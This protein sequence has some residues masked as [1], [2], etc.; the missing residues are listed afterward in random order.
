MKEQT[1]NHNREFEEAEIVTGPQSKTTKRF[2]AGQNFATNQARN[3]M[4][5]FKKQAFLF[6]FAWVSA[7]VFGIIGFFTLIGWILFS[8]LPDALAGFLFAI[9]ILPVMVIV[10]V[11]YKSLRFVSKKS[12]IQKK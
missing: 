11:V 10:Y 12:K 7:I 4:Q 6:I 2:N 9:L 3:R 1:Q 5:D 8:F